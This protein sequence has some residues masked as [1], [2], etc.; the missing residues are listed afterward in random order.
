MSHIPAPYKRF[1]QDYPEVNRAYSD[2]AR[3]CH[4]AGPLDERSRRLVKLGIAVGLCSDGAVKSHARRALSIGISADE[5]RHAVL[6]G[7]STTGFPRSIAALEWVEE[8]IS[9]QQG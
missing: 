5:I 1:Q 3:A 7:M 8:V 2:F 9:A 4:E 6:L